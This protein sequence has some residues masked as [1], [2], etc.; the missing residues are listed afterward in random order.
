[1]ITLH[2]N[3]NE[4]ATQEEIEAFFHAPTAEHTNI[5]TFELTNEQKRQLDAAQSEEECI[6]LLKGWGH[7][8]FRP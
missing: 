7:D 1:M 8:I 3:N 4:A 6:A 5:T 2:Y